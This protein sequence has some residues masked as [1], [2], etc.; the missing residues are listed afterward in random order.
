MVASRRCGAAV[1]VGAPVLKQL[2]KNGTIARNGVDDMVMSIG[3]ESRA[4]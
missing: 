3:G 2:Q 4:N 1:A